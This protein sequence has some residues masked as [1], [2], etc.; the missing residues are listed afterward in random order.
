MRKIL[1]ALLAAALLALSAACLAEGSV[2]VPIVTMTVNS[3]GDP[4]PAP[5]STPASFQTPEAIVAVTPT[6]VPTQEP[7]PTVPLTPAPTQLPPPTAVP[8]M[9]TLMSDSQPT[10]M[11]VGGI[12]SGGSTVLGSDIPRSEITSV[13]F[14]PSHFGATDDAWDVSADR[15]GSVLAWVKDGA[16]TIASLGGVR[17]NADSSYL[18]AG[19]SSVT[20]IDFNRSFLT[21]GALDMSHMFDSCFS[22]AELDVTE[23]N[24]A[25]VLDMSYMFSTCAALTALDLSNFDT[26]RVRNMDGMFFMDASLA[27]L[28]VTAFNTASARSMRSMFESCTA[29]KSLDLSGFNTSSASDMRY[30]FSNCAA[31]ESISVLADFAAGKDAAEMYSGCA[32]KLS[33]VA[34]EPNGAGEGG[35]SAVIGELTAAEWAKY[36]EYASLKKWAR[37]DNVRKL[38]TRLTELGYGVG[39]IDG[40]YGPDTQKAISRWQRDHGYAGNGNLNAEQAMELFN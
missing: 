6:P 2:I 40:V 1:L 36:D 39:Y 14:E 21:E 19:Y 18:F 33:V 25:G 4:T 24:T 8:A 29:L 11:A 32:A 30:M 10:T 16:L 35:E 9:G 17:A 20:S 5:T 13:R 26:S 3:V 37:G 28:D 27:E 7:T 22:L 23:L 12:F 15:D 31:L 34:G 38:Q